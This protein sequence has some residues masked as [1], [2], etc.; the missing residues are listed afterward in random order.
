VVVDP[1][2][3]VKDVVVVPS[4]LVSELVVDWS[5]RESNAVNVSVLKD[6]ELVLALPVFVPVAELV[7]V[8]PDDESFE[9]ENKSELSAVLV[10]LEPPGLRS[11]CQ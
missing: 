9:D 1:S 4:A 6:D 2:A 7:A 11:D 3:F 8:V 5:C 10:A